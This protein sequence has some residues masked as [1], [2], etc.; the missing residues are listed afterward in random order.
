MSFYAALRN[1]ISS[2]PKDKFMLLGDFNARVRKNH[3]TWNA[4]GRYGIDNIDYNGLLLLDLY[5]EFNL[6]ICNTF[7]RL[8]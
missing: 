2:I 6:A 4:T 5:S 7:F 3:V 8:N 1:T